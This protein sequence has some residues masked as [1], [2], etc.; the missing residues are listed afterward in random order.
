MVHD[1]FCRILHQRASERSPIGS[2]LNFL[3]AIVLMCGV[4]LGESAA[5]QATTKP[6]V[7]ADVTGGGG[8]VSES[9]KLQFTQKNVQAQ[10]Q[11]LEGRMFQLAETVREAEPESS[12]RLLLAVRKAREQLIMEQMKEILEKLSTK[13]LA[14]ATVGTK[15]VLTKLA[16]LRNL[17][18]ATDLEFQLQ[19]ERLRQLQAA[20][21]KVDKLI[22]EEQQQQKHTNSLD[23]LLKKSQ[24][25][26][27]Q[28]FEDAKKEQEANRGKT[29]DVAGNLKQLGGG[30]LDKPLAS[31]GEG[32]KAMSNAEGA[33]GN[34]KPGSASSSQGEATKKLQEARDELEKERQ[35]VQQELQKQVRG[36]VMENLQ[37]MLDRQIGVRQATETLSPRIGKGG[38]RAAIAQVMQLEPAE[39]RIATI[40]QQTLD[41]VN[42]TEFSVALPPALEN[43]H[44]NMLYAAGDL[45]GGRADER[46]IATMQGIEQDLRDLLET[47]KELSRNGDGKAG[48]C[49]GCKG[50]K[51]KL[52]A[53]LKV[54]RM[55]QLRVN[56][57]T[58]EADADK[59]RA[60]A[61]AELPPELRE[62]VG[63]VRDAEGLVRDAMERLHQQYGPGAPDEG[64]EKG[65]GTRDN[66]L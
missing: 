16:E 33:L 23:D 43:L 15:E 45:K 28:T 39:L 7:K 36:V 11:E 13:D 55:L 41:L 34:S 19:L 42:E 47:F 2:R 21:A 12:T 50:N 64:P 65:E 63:K 6:A 29:D 27:P 60:A 9:E 10:M 35:K 17:L 57:Q 37:E 4:A 18:T 22:K 14:N 61:A 52:L 56:K 62:K 3:L 8:G 40:C 48:N 26:K 51:N 46:V 44:R 30:G 1:M 20:I 66:P 49:K 24:E 59:H 31:L 5:T 54:V 25:V 58:L 53:E 38:D 32:S